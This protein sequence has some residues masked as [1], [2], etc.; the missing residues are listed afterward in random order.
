MFLFVLPTFSGAFVANLRTSHAK[1][2]NRFRFVS[3][4]F[5]AFAARAEAFATKKN[6]VLHAGNAFAFF[7]AL[8]T[9]GLASFASRDAGAV[10][11]SDCRHDPSTP[12]WSF[13][14]APTPPSLTN[15][16]EGGPIS[17][18][19]GIPQSLAWWQVIDP[20]RRAS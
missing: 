2:R 19:E 15:Q 12:S 20:R 16:S 9:G 5:S 1:L 8:A 18:T 4:F 11:V 14:P 7:G 10:V 6:A 13:F 3:H 17:A